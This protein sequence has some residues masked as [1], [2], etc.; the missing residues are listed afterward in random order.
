MDCPCDNFSSARQSLLTSQKT[1][2]RPNESKNEDVLM[3]NE[4]SAEDLDME[5]EIARKSRAID[6]VE[7]KLKELKKASE[8][9]NEEEECNEEPE[10]L[11]KLPVIYG[12]SEKEREE[13]GRFHIPYRS[14][15]EVCV[16]AKK[17][18]PP[19]YGVKDK[20]T[21]PVI[22]MDYMFV[23]DK[24]ATLVLKDANFGGVWALVVIRKGNGGEYAAAR[25]ADILHK[26]GY[27]RCVLKCDQEPAIVDVSKEVRKELW[28]EIKD[29]AKDAKEKH[30]GDVTVVDEY[31][32]IEIIQEHSPVG[33]SSSNG[34]VERAIQEVAGQIRALKLHIESEA[35][36]TIDASHPLW[37]WL[38]E[39]AA[40]GI[41]MYH[42]GTDGKT[43]RQRTRGRS[44]MASGVAF[45]EQVLYKPMKTV[46]IP[47][48]EARWL[49]GTWIG[50]IDH[51][52]EHIIGTSEG[53]VKCRAIH[54]RE[55]ALRWDVEAMANVKGLPWKP[56]PN[57]RSLRIPTRIIHDDDV[58]SEGEGEDPDM[59]P[60]D[61]EGEYEVKIDEK[62]DEERQREAIR[63]SKEEEIFERRHT[64]PY[65][66]YVM[67]GDIIK[68][69]PTPRCAGCK[70]VLG[71]RKNAEGHSKECKDRIQ[72]AMR[73]DPDDANR[74]EKDEKRK[75]KREEEYEEGKEQEK[76]KHE[77]HQR[78]RKRSRLDERKE[79]GDPSS[80]SCAAASSSERRKLTGEIQSPNFTK[81]SRKLTG[82]IQSPNFTKEAQAG[83]I[84]K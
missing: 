65:K 34:T 64:K 80:S 66:M 82:E 5:A 69:G 55:R 76:R 58:D 63:K 18:N 8:R 47:K 25:V 44:S 4:E 84:Q 36:T 46:K 33:E 83:Q 51:T 75:E 42:V 31:T 57:R 54:P 40:M 15:C 73:L 78:Q 6:E 19:H 2:I 81:G 17:K 32:P 39:Y 79:E 35:N 12:P 45:G 30:D 27:P 1:P 41:Y 24:S 21:Y 70:Y 3:A 67:K 11:K 68:Y 28:K 23:S 62:E 20:R 60:E 14:W 43:A 72:E 37:P 71:E 50:I 13:H 74:V 59:A 61:V 29:I 48:S 56:N 10:R 52:N 16:Q 7:E 49:R 22:S 77:E 53:V 9:M 26:I 38:I